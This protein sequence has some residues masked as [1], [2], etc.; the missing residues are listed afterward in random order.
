MSACHT[1]V[2]VE[3]KPVQLGNQLSL[4]DMIAFVDEQLPQ[5]AIHF[6]RKIH[7]ADIDVALQHKPRYFRTAPDQK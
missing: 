7:L 5:T 6:E 2:I 3:V 1:Q 4:L